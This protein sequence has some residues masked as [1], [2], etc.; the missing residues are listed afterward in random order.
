MQIHATI[1]QPYKAE[2]ILALLQKF[3][4]AFKESTVSA[5]Y[6]GMVIDFVAKSQD[7]HLCHINM[8]VS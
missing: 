3:C 5:I 6:Y 4:L 1:K 7:C 2:L 8:N